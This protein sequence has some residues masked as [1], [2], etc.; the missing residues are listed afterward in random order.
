MILE[1]LS[2]QTG[3]PES[4]IVTLAKGA[5]H[6]Y[7]TYEIPKRVGG[8]RTIHHPSRRLKAVQRW[9]L[10]NVISDLPIH[11]AAAAYRRAHNILDNA[12]R[13]SRSRFLLRMDFANFFP[14][15]SLADIARFIA[16]RRTI[17]TGWT[18][19]DIE[20][21]CQLVCRNGALTIGAP[22]SPALSNALCFELDAQLETLAARY[23]VTYSRYADDLFFSTAT[24]E[25]LRE[26]ENQ[27]PVLVRSLAVPAN[28]ALNLAKTRHSSRRGAR[29]V[30]GIV[31]GSDG[32]AYI[33]R[34]L[35]RLIRSQIHKF[36]T[37]DARAKARLAGLVA[38]AVGLDPNFA[39][40][41]IKKYGPKRVKE[42][43][44]AR[45]T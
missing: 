5:S 21:F 1:K 8:K 39:N 18:T 6:E 29:R 3:I 27:V 17:F 25:V 40:S 38:Y 35:K 26:V 45:V 22:T 43:R 33:G 31:L 30:T 37:L 15:I 20:V 14:S 4:L 23:D 34:Q 12:S 42:V 44:S 24:P 13:H 28:L 16:D 19:L 7:K 41:L 32:N 2:S 36:A 9:L 10:Q 11:R